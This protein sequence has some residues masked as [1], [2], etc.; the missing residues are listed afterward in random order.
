MTLAEFAAFVVDTVINVNAAI[1]S[2][3]TTVT[4]ALIIGSDVRTF[5]VGAWVW[6]AMV[7]RIWRRINTSSADSSL[8]TFDR[9]F[10]RIKPL[11]KQQVFPIIVAPAN[12][13]SL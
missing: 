5:P 11:V 13:V 6:A 4:G 3:P 10:C 1:Q 2:F 7:C 8:E 9:Q 12:S